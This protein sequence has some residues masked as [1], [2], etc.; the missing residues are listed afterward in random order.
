MCNTARLSSGLSPI[1]GRNWARTRTSQYA[2]PHP[3]QRSIRDIRQGRSRPQKYQTRQ[4][5]RYNEWYMQPAQPS[6]APPLSQ[7]GVC[8]M[9]RGLSFSAADPGHSR[10]VC[11]ADQGSL[12]SAFRRHAFP[13]LV[14]TSAILNCN[15]TIRFDCT[16]LWFP[17]SESASSSS[18]VLLVLLGSSGRSIDGLLPRTGFPSATTSFDS[19]QARYW[20]VLCPAMT[21]LVEGW[22]FYIVHCLPADQGFL[23][24]A[25]YIAECVT[26]FYTTQY[27]PKS[28]AG[29][30]KRP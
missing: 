4:V 1:K 29:Q 6:P 15:F 28:Q 18:A 16:R 27:T 23:R 11:L 25:D 14:G 7:T 2:S 26:P 30:R 5:Q 21:V 8:C 19:A 10:R 22:T 17:I 13:A 3:C 12:E 24:T 9:C 20:Q